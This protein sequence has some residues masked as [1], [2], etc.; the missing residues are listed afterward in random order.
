AISHQPSAISHQPSAISHQPSAI[1]HQPSANYT[2]LLNN[3]VNTVQKLS[4]PKYHFSHFPKPCLPIQ[5]ASVGSG[6]TL[7]N[8]H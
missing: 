1:S 8:G 3:R 7:S 2:H 4:I 5:A 6:Y